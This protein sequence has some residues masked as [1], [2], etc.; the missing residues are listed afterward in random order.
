MSEIC[1][2]DILWAREYVH[3]HTLM[4]THYFTYIQYIHVDM[5]KTR[6]SQSFRIYFLT[7][8]HSGK[9]GQP[10][11]SIN[12]QDTHVTVDLEIKLLAAVEILDQLPRVAG[13]FGFAMLQEVATNLTAPLVSAENTWEMDTQNEKGY[14]VPDVYNIYIYVYIYMYV[15][16]YIYTY[17]WVYCTALSKT[18]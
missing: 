2:R 3:T 8:A 16:I 18:I 1:W 15:Y 6:A 7:P 12:C 11:R 10:F 4:N 14:S 17:A 5:F 9:F 13:P